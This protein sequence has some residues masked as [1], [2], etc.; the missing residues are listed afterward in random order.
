MDAVNAP[1]RAWYAAVGLATRAKVEPCPAVPA[2]L[3]LLLFALLAIAPAG[4]RAAAP[5][6]T[7]FPSDRLTV[8]D[9]GQLTGKR[10]RL[11]LP[12]CA[13][14]P[15]DCDDIRLLN[16][17][18][19]FDLDPRV[20]ISF[21][22][23]IDVGKVTRDTL[24]LQK[25]EERIGLNRLVWS[26]ARRTLYGQP[27]RLLEEGATYRLV[28]TPAISGRGASASFTTMSA[29]DPLQRMRRQLDDGSAY[30]A[31]G[32]PGMSRG[33]TIDAA[34]PAPAVLDM[35]RNNDV[36]GGEFVEERIIN[37]ARDN[38]GTYA[39]GFLRAPSWLDADRTIPQVGTRSVPQVRGAETVG[40]AII[41][42]AGTPPEGG[43]PVAI[44]GPGV[45]RSKYDVF[46]SA[47]FNARKGFATIA[48]DPVGH[49]FGP[50][51]VLDVTT[52]SGVTQVPM[53]GRALSDAEGDGRL[54]SEE[55]Q[56]PLP[57]HPKSS[58][59]FR[60]G[61]RQTALDNMALVRAIQRGVDV[62]GD[63]VSDL[64]KERIVYYAVSLGGIYGTMFLA[65][66]PR[67][68]VGASSVP[69]GPILEIA[70]LA[71]GFR[72]QVADVLKR[73]RPSLLNGGRDGFTESTPLFVDPPVLKPARG[74]IPIQ[75]LG[76]VSN[77]LNRPGSPETYSPLLRLRPASDVPKKRV[78]YQ[79]AFGDQTVPN[80]TSA[81]LVRAGGLQDVTS[82]YRNDRTP[83]ASANPHGY[84]LDPRITGRQPAQNMFSDF[85]TS[86]GTAIVDPDGAGN[87]F[88]VPIVDFAALE[89]L[90]YRLAPAEGEP[91]PETAQDSAAPPVVRLKLSVTPR[92]VRAGRGVRISVRVTSGGR[93]VRGA[94]I[95]FAGRRVRTGR[96]GRAV[97]KVRFRRTGIR[98]LVVRSGS[99]RATA[100][101]R[102]R[103]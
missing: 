32:I 7:L 8:A 25:G 52:A 80:P 49:S 50:Q 83:T 46:L 102:I 62:N 10:V 85:Y 31:A 90:N 15:S 92:R 72:E 53:H 36:G 71:P 61:L 1:A 33:I 84:L 42:P 57:P 17:L 26:P 81:T 11:P 13:A 27:E 82:L 70:R 35:V 101:V 100:T 16:Q 28:V 48:I 56:A 75:D 69:G 14:R 55:L 88:E 22:V 94:R 12:D 96:R 54:D 103:K 44:H 45:T 73:R 21:G 19:G 9:S 40:V 2:R 99:R 18:D 93:P 60:D 98:K 63:G 68:T 5:T 41:L 66:E 6:P 47:D 86:D 97:L 79:F 30:D 95:T 77:W 87:V 58:L 3:T 64:S 29:T 20:A 67:V 38:A 34:F 23:D 78:I 89:R 76:G 39:F 43:W 74:A 91:P 4:T 51:G 65:A 59:G 37:T 24:Y